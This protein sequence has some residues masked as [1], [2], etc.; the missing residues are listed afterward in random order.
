MSPPFSGKN[1]SLGWAMELVK[2]SGFV[3]EISVSL[4]WLTHTGSK[5][6]CLPKHPSKTVQRGLVWERGFFPYSSCESLTQAHT[7]GT[8]GRFVFVGNWSLGFLLFLGPSPKS[9]S[10]FMRRSFCIGRSSLQ[11]TNNVPWNIISGS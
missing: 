9:F 4:A 7:G 5:K 3:Y 1:H 8:V 10:L 6:S 2:C 11:S